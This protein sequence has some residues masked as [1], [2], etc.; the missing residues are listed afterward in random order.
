MVKYGN[1]LGIVHWI[2]IFRNL[3]LTINKSEKKTT[4]FGVTNWQTV[5]MKSHKNTEQHEASCKS[6]HVQNCDKLAIVVHIRGEKNPT[7]L[8]HVC[9]GGQLFM[10]S[11]EVNTCKSYVLNQ[12]Q[13]LIK[14]KTLKVAATMIICM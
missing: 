6:F 2:I 5:L 7:H 9:I 10:E 11:Y 4:L 1:W 3:K 8:M 12:N 14:N 13:H